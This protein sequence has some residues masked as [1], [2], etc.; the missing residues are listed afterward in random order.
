MAT[1]LLRLDSQKSRSKKHS[2]TAL[3]RGQAA[4]PRGSAQPGVGK[5]NL[6]D[7]LAADKPEERLTR[8]SKIWKLYANEAKVYDEDLVSENNAYLDLML[9][10]VSAISESVIPR[11]LRL[12]YSQGY[13][14][15]GNCHR[16]SYRLKKHDD[17]RCCGYF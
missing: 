15:L 14:V 10:F 6:Y 13:L 7:Q 9:V 8:D 11:L 16:I 17:T 12:S 4:A 1:G 3:L 5:S 2:G